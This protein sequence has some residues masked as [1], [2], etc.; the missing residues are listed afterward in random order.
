[1][2]IRLF[3]VNNQDEIETE[4]N[5]NESNF[6]FKT[7]ETIIWINDYFSALFK[8]NEMNTNVSVCIGFFYYL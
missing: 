7:C 6:N 5:V 8:F 2:Q 1:M 4:T 3:F